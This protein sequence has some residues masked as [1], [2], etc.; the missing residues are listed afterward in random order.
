M[1]DNINL[2]Y[3]KVFFLVAKEGNITRVSEKMY[4]SQSAVTQTIQK[5]ENKLGYN[6]FVRNSK[7]V[8]LTDVGAGL[9]KS[10]VPVFYNLELVDLYLKNIDSLNEGEIKI[11]CGTNLGKKVLIDPIC[12]F[13]ADYP[14]VKITQFDGTKNDMN[15]KLACGKIDIFISQNDE[16]MQ[17]KYNFLPI[18]TEKYIFACS[19]SYYKNHYQ[20]GDFTYIL[21]SKNTKSREVFESYMK[22][23]GLDYNCNIEVVG[24]N[25][26]IEMCKKD[27]GIIMVPSYLI[28]DEINNKMLVEIKVKNLPIVEYYAYTN[29]HVSNK[30]VNCFLKYIVQ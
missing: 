8:K 24:Y 26:M 7:S 6:L 10:L 28:E 30:L 29:P 25:L 12:N 3:L 13:S 19:Q 15:E 18:L 11:G 2:E 5:L 1:L 14:N 20:N 4:I 21:Q 27:K 17:K 9:Y 16:E 23:L 22:N